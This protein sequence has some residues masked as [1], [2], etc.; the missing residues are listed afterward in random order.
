MNA[1]CLDG[2]AGGRPQRPPRVPRPGSEIAV[3]ASPRPAGSWGRAATHHCWTSFS[4]TAREN[5][6][7]PLSQ[8]GVPEPGS[9]PPTRPVGAPAGP[10]QGHAPREQSRSG[11]RWPATQQGTALAHTFPTPTMLLVGLP[12]RASYP[13]GWLLPALLGDGL[14]HIPPVSVPGQAPR[15][16]GCRLPGGA[17]GRLS[18]SSAPRRPA[19]SRRPVP[20]APL[21]SQS[22]ALSQAR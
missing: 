8:G 12:R 7:G 6:K 9:R 17:A 15:E 13:R 1:G 2:A 18:P 5:R 14:I 4:V 21:S 19:P 11:A 22:R 10:E 20:P 16:L 3:P